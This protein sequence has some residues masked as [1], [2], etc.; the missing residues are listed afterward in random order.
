MRQMD[1][2]MPPKTYSSVNVPETLAMQQSYSLLPD[3]LSLPNP[4]EAA[5]KLLQSPD[6]GKC[7]PKLQ[8]KLKT[9]SGEL[10]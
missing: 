6:L 9:G 2:R 3:L 7:S 4:L 1:V 8:R 10:H 5:T